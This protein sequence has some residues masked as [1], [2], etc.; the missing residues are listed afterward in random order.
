MSIYFEESGDMTAPSV[1]FIHGGGMAGWMWKKQAEYFRSYHCLIPDLPEHGKSTD[2][3]HVSIQD[4]ACRIA[5]LIEKH[6]NGGKADI[7]G[8]SLG[9]KVLI[10][11]L[12]KRPE[13]VKHAVVASA[14]YR[15]VPLMKL[16]HKM[17]VYK[18]TVSMM[19]SGWFLT[20]T[21]KQFTFPDAAFEAECVKDF[22][23][24]TAG[25][26]Y[27]VYE[28]LYRCVKL[29]DG[30][31]GADVPTLAVAGEKELKAMKLSVDDIVRTMPNARGLII[32]QGL[33]TYPWAM[34]EEFNKIVGE[35]IQS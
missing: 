34:H 7:V 19:K 32:K 2:E 17:F 28:E 6:A 11:L 26:L 8:H 3:G 4:G 14:L 35:W 22:R 10:E 23:R 9:A 29:P 25:F 24:Q 16:S 13:L 31:A 27:R 12:S 30:L 21:I 20:R 18:L 5:E 15:P 1:V 33:H